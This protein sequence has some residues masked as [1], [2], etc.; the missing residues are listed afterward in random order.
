LIYFIYI[1]T[2]AYRPYLWKKNNPK[3]H[4]MNKRKYKIRKRLRVLGYLPPVGSPMTDEEQK[5]YDDIGKEDFTFWDGVKTQPYNSGY[6]D[7]KYRVGMKSDEYRI[8]LRAKDNAKHRNFEFNLDLEDIDI[9]D[10]CPYLDVQLTTNVKDHH[11][12]NYYSIDRI[13]SKKG[14]IKGNVQ[15]ISHL[16]NAMKNA[17]T[18][19]QLTTF[20]EN[21]LKI[22]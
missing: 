10:R 12:D 21:V 22:P 7:P 11:E 17:A 3:K 4:T 19:E 8:W 14:Y 18:K 15:A 13:N 9:P 5:I 20:A 6:S 1:F 2:M 16:A